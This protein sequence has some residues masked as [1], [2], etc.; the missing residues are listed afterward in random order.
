[1]GLELVVPPEQEPVTLDEAKNWLRVDHSEDDGLI[2]GLVAAAREEC[3]LITGRQLPVATYNYYLDR[4]PDGDTLYLPRPPLQSVVEV[5][6]I[7][8]AGGGETIWDSSN[9]LVDVRSVPGRLVLAP[10]RAW[11]QA[12]GVPNSVR[13]KFVCGYESVPEPLRGW[14]RLRIGDLYEI[15]QS[16]VIENRLEQPVRSAHVRW[17]DGL[18]DNYRVWR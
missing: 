5:A 1:M 6:Y 8:A 17:Y 12:R 11:P 4:W 16:V 9:Y 14:I 13:V 2:G 7:P 15:R 3:E 10:G 18:L